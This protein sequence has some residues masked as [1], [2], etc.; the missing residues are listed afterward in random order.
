M[1]DGRMEGGREE[2]RRNKGRAKQER[3]KRR[4][5]RELI[6]G[7]LAVP[8]TCSSPSFVKHAPCDDPKEKSVTFSIIATWTCLRFSSVRVHAIRSLWFSSSRGGWT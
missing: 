3:E 4:A 6:E 8:Q 7:N 5:K 2:Q 1:V